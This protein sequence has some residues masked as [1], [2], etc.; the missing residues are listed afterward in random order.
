[1]K[2]YFIECINTA[3]DNNPGFKTGT[4]HEFWYGKNE[5]LIANF[6][7]EEPPTNQPNLSYALKEYGFK[8]KAGA[9]AA[10]KRHLC[11]S[12]DENDLEMWTR[13]VRIAEVEV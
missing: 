11:M 2:R 8:N 13:E 5:E 9:T 4:K 10:Y 12:Q 6:N 1:M 7:H 3:T